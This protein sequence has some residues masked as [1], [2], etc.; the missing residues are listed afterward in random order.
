MMASMMAASL[1][2]VAV[3]QSINV[4]FAPPDV[5]GP[6]GED[7][8]VDS[9]HVFSSSRSTASF[10]WVQDHAYGNN[11]RLR[12]DCADSS[13]PQDHPEDATLMILDRESV[14]TGHSIWHIERLPGRYRVVVRYSD[15]DPNR[16][17]TSTL[18]CRL[19]GESASVGLFSTRDTGPR[20]FEAEITVEATGALANR[21]QFSGEYRLGNTPG[22]SIVSSIRIEALFTTS[23]SG[24]PTRAPTGWYAS[25]GHAENVTAIQTQLLGLTRSVGQLRAAVGAAALAADVSSLRQTVGLIENNADQGRA[26]LSTA[27]SATQAELSAARSEITALKSSITAAVSLI[28]D[29]ARSGASAGE[30]PSI[31]ATGDSVSIKSLR[32][33]VQVES[34]ECTAFDLC[35]IAQALN[36]LRQD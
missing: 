36:A 25:P 21:I 16:Y 22:C 9:G 10:G 29:V 11:Q 2:S 35:S 8:V 7:W 5:C 26:E 34:S 1:V 30:P 24:S 20:E 3:G 23:P 33:I 6:D 31:E 19:Q 28:P 12:I 14:H 13:V 27:L 32:G 15:L 17:T 4:N 18:G